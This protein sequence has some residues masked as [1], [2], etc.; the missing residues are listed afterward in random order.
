MILSRSKDN[1]FITFSSAS[2]ISFI[3]THVDWIANPS[4]LPKSSL[5]SWTPFSPRLYP[6]DGNF[7]SA[8]VTLCVLLVRLI[9]KDHK[10]ASKDY[11]LEDWLTFA[12]IEFL[13]VIRWIPTLWTGGWNSTLLRIDNYKESR[14]HGDEFSMIDTICDRFEYY[15]WPWIRKCEPRIQTGC[16]VDGVVW[17]RV[18]ALRY[19]GLLTSNT[20]PVIGVSLV[21]P[22]CADRSY[23]SLLPKWKPR[24]NIWALGRSLVQRERASSKI[25]TRFALLT[26][27]LTLLRKTHLPSSFFYSEVEERNQST[28]RH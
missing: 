27:W 16:T 23:V 11:G 10:V 25:Y 17:L 20:R 8:S 13:I 22:S 14:S 1:W 7:L 26:A 19:H 5:F 2:P 28:G 12:V 15:W 21:L 18:E 4:R 24:T 3:V 6:L 9:L